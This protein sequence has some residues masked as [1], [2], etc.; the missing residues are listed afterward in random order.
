[1]PGGKSQLDAAE[2]VTADA[3]DARRHAPGG[4]RGDTNLQGQ[5]LGRKGRETRERILDSARALIE[6]SDESPPSLSAVA[7]AASLRMSS[8]YVYFK[9]MTELVLALLEPVTASSVDAYARLLGDYWPDEEIEERASEFVHAFHRFWQ[10]HSRLLHLR[11]AMADQFDERMMA[12]RIAMARPVI[13]DLARQM[14]RKGGGDCADASEL[15]SILFTGLERVV[16]VATD[17]RMQ[18]A[19]PR[20]MG[21]PFED[22][23]LGLQGYVLALVIAGRRAAA[24]G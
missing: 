4:R 18:A 15:A 19:L 21:A 14:R 5:R 8:I 24:R 22:K 13:V 3:R 17:E 9:D 1:M 20:A 10:T 23:T 2:A 11:N 12:Q 7:R 16:T 6:E